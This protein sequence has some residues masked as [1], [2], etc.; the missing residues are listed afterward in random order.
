MV[1][2]SITTLDIINLLSPSRQSQQSKN[3]DN[4]EDAMQWLATLT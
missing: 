1:I 2:S 3:F 4:E